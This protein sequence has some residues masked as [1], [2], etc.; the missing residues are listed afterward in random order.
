[1]T[2]ATQEEERRK[3]E[4]WALSKRMSIEFCDTFNGYRFVD[5]ED[6]WAIWQAA[7]AQ[8]PTTVS[9]AELAKVIQKTFPVLRTKIDENGKWRATPL[10][11][12]AF[13]TVVKAVIE[14]LKQQGVRIEYV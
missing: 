2:P 12:E 10:E 3:F 11:I 4:E 6:A 5:T 7:R 1:M 8:Q 13:D 9:L 14:S